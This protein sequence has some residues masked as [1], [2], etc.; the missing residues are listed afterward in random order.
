MNKKIIVVSLLAIATIVISALVWFLRGT[1][2]PVLN[3]QG[4][5]AD[6]QRDLIIVALLLSA[7]VVLPVFILTFFIAWKYRASNHK[8]KYTPDWQSSRLLETI[9]WGIPCVIILVLSVITWQTSHSLDPYRPLESSVRPVQVQVV[10]LQWKWLFIYPEY[11]VASVNMLH[12]PEKTPINFTITADAPMNSFWI[13]SLGGQVYAMSGMSTKLHLIANETGEYAG[14]SANISG[15]GFARM[16]FTVKSVSQSDFTA[17]AGATQK[18][19]PALDQARYNELAKPSEL[20]RPEFYS[21]KDN[22]L[23]D[24]IVMKYM[25]HGHGGSTESIT[26]REE[27]GSQ[28]NHMNHSHHESMPGMEGTR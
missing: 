25:G 10:A 9:W 28:H 12:I 24:T 21:L 23:Y 19:S 5:I 1:D 18:S 17:W 26:P 8:A 15:E 4:S 6:Q 22:D 7:I 27:E 2:I 14:K 11:Q 16:N 13:P 3:P 20:K